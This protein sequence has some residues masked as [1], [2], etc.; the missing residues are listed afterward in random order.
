[1]AYNPVD[2]NIYS[3]TGEGIAYR[4]D[5]T[6]GSATA[7]PEHDLQM[8]SDYFCY[9]V[10]MPRDFDMWGAAFDENG[11]PWLVDSGCNGSFFVADFASGELWNQGFF[12]DD[13]QAIATAPNFE[14]PSVGNILLT[15]SGAGTS[16]TG[17]SGEGLAETG[18][19]ASWT[20]GS[21]AVGAIV[22]TA[23][24]ILRRRRA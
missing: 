11:N 6:N 5:K 13:T 16:E 24:A 9:G 2:D 20:V 17:G 23:G 21:L 22:I 3:Y 4:I 19:D 10:G 7:V 12:H 14:L 8:N 18:S 1:M 15:T